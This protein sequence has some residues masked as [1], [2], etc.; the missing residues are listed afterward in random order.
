VLKV[1][2]L[3]PLPE[4]LVRMLFAEHLE[5]Y[6]MEAN[7][8]AINE[9]DVQSLKRE[10]GDTDVVI[11]DYTFRIPITTEMVGSMTKVKLIAQPSTGYDHIDIEACR[12]RGYRSA[13]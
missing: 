2:V 10:L 7:F 9:P 8:V 13:T 3:S 12:K 11:G 6:N 1:L 5:K 4:G